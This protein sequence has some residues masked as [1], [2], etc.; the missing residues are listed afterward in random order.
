MRD[1]GLFIVFRFIGLLGFGRIRWD[2]A[3]LSRILTAKGAKNA[4]GKEIF[5]RL[6]TKVPPH[7]VAL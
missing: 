5:H 7:F 4:K 6:E 2:W 3:G 1:E